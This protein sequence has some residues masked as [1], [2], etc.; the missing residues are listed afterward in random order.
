MKKKLIGAVALMLLAGSAYATPVAYMGSNATGDEWDRP[1]G[2]GPDISGLGP[3]EYTVQAFF[4][5]TDD[6]YDI[7]SVQDY[8][9]YIHLYVGAFDPLDQ[10]NGLLAG[11]DDG[12]GG[13]GTSEILGIG[14]MANTQYFLVTSAFSFGQTGT[15]TNTIADLMGDATITLG[16]LPTDVPEPGTLLLVGLGLL[17]MGARRKARA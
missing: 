1:I 9:G 4:T 3:V 10:L 8:D 13:I 11:D 16:T 17:G 7:T 5:D 15:F 14:L 2:G 6:A 12:A